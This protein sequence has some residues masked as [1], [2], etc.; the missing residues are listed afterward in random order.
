[1]HA[2]NNPSSRLIPSPNAMRLLST[3]PKFATS[4]AVASCSVTS[5]STVNRT[6]NFSMRRTARVALNTYARNPR[7]RFIGPGAPAIIDASSPT[8]IPIANLSPLSSR[9]RSILASSPWSNARTAL[10]DFIGIPRVRAT[11]LPVPPGRIPT[12]GPVC[13]SAPM[14]SIAVPSPPSVNT[15]SY[16][17]ACSVARRAPCPGESVS[18]VSQCTPAS[19]NARC[20]LGNARRPSREAG[21]TIRS[22]RLI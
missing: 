11:I 16:D 13:A 18:I 5:P 3:A 7:R 10:P 6:L 9:P 8:P 1:M 17:C 12:G 19:A 20:A 15:A 14:T 2:S 4:T 21:F 22:A